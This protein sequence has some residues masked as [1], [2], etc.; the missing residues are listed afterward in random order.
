M[1]GW[2]E[3]ES[4]P[5][6]FF[7]FLRISSLISKDQKEKNVICTMDDVQGDVL[8][9]PH[10]RTPADCHFDLKYVVLH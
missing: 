3:N 8:E 7:C 10:G 1:Q 6:I 5:M 9:P 2:L 4:K